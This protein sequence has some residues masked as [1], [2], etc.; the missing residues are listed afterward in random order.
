MEG[1]FQADFN[2]LQTIE[3]RELAGCETAAAT[4][5]EVKSSFV[6]RT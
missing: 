4:N 6:A 3:E 5:G 1:A 2:H